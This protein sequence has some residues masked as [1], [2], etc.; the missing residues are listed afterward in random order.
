MSAVRGAWTAAIRLRAVIAGLAL[1]ACGTG[2]GAAMH[3]DAGVP[4]L[5]TGA[6]AALIVIAALL[7]ARTLI[8]SSIPIVA[9]R[10]IGAPFAARAR[11]LAV[12]RLCDPDAPGRA[13]PRAPGFP[14]R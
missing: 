13:R 4:P 14:L 1:L 6:A 3:G 12:P 10:P 5:A 2:I 11:R 7:A 8:G 9:A